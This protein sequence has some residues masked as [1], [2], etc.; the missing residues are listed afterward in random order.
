M[1]VDLARRLIRIGKVPS[2][3]VERALWRWV[4][5]G[6]PFLKVL[7]ESQ[8]EVSQLLERVAE[9]ASIP[10]VRRVVA[11]PGLVEELPRG[12]CERLL[13]VP[14]RRDPQSGSVD[15]AAADPLDPHLARELGFHLGGPVRLLRAEV[16]EL[17]LALGAIEQAVGRDDTDR[18]A[19]RGAPHEP[20]ARARHA[21]DSVPASERTPAFGTPVVRP[22]KVILPVHRS[23]RASDPPRSQEPS[24][25]AI[26]LVR[27]AHEAAPPAPNLA[28]VEEQAD[29][30]ASAELAI[31]SSADRV[32][33][34][35]VDVLETVSHVAVVLTSRGSEF[36]GRAGTQGVDP[37]LLRE[38]RIPADTPSVLLTACDVGYYLGELPTTEAH[39]ALG[40]ALAEPGEVLVQPVRVGGRAA[41]VVVCSV[42]MDSARVTRR[43]EEL[44]QRAGAAL[45]RI[46]LE[47]KL[48]S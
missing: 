30:L 24:E 34:V 11:H 20:G 43:V 32:V 41:L 13:V 29:Q 7:T 3:A 21:F 27:R 44:S 48:R 35:L 5:Q 15:V 12:L 6:E 1:S 14:L 9:R 25:P 33:Q 2:V 45:E 39:A 42:G 16:P 10:L 8:P 22:D 26:P 38:V 47:R 46:L 4:N 23:P 37:E 18:D 40:R 19:T 28:E 36:V 31:A 17:V